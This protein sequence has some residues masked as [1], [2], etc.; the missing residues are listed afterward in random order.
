M[1]TFLIHS[2]IQQTFVEQLICFCQ[3][4]EKVGNS[5]MNQKQCHR[6]GAYI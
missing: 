2:F 5:T 4:L 6:D 3:A 1:G